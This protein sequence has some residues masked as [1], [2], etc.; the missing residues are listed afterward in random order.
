MKKLIASLAILHFA[1]LVFAQPTNDD[2]SGV[3]HLGTAPICPFPDTFSNLD[4]TQSVVFSS[5]TANVPSCF[6][7]GAVNRDVWFSFTVPAVGGQVDF[8]V[9]LTGVNG[10]NG[11]IVQP[12]IAAY[13]GDCELDGLS[14]LNCATSI[15]GQTNVSLDLIALDPGQLVYL[16][17]SDWSSSATPN[18]GDFELC[19]KA[20][21]PVYNMGE[22]GFTA[23]CAGTLYD[24]GGPTDDYSNNELQTFTICPQEFTQ[25]ISL[26]IVSIS[27][28]D[29]YDFLKIYAGE[30]T[31]SPLFASFSGFGTNLQLQVMGQCATFLFDSDNSANDEGFEI[32][33]EC[34]PTTCLISPPST[35]AAPTAIPALPY[36][37]TNLTT[38][39]SQNDLDTSPCNDDD[40]MQGE[41]VIFTYN[42]PGDEC[43]SV[44]ITGS[45]G[46][47]AIGI[48]DNCPEGAGPV[49]CLAQ[50]GGDSELSNPSING[51]F[52]ALP[53]TYYI[54][55]DN[56]NF[57]TP[58][59]IEVEEV[60]CP[61]I[62]PSAAFCENAQSIN[63][64][65]SL[66]SIVYIA[67][68]DGDPDFLNN[69]VNL[70]CWNGNV[71]QNY[72]F[73]YFEA[74]T[75]GDFAFVVQAANPDESSDID[76][77]V[78]GPIA[79]VDSIC[80]FAAT[81][82]PT[83]SSYGPY[84]VPTGLAY[85]NPNNNAVVTDTCEEAGVQPNVGDSFVL[86]IQVKAGEHYLVLIND[87][88]DVIESG[89]I[90]I[91]FS[92]TTEGVLASADGDFMTS[93]TD[94][95]IC[96]GDSVQLM[97]SGG[98]IF[99]WYP[100]TDLSCQYCP[101]PVSS[102]SENT[103]YHVA[104]HSLCE[105]DTI[106]VSVEILAVSAGPDLTICTGED[107]QIDAG[108]N[109]DDVQYQW[110][111]PAGFLSCND[112]PNPMVTGIQAGTFTISVSA[113]A[114]SCNLM[115]EMQL[116]VL[117]S[118]APVY[119]I[120]PDQNLCI[121]A[122]V[123]LGGA[124]IPGLIYNWT[125]N[126]PGFSS[127]LAN[128]ST[129]VAVNTIYYLEVSNGLCPVPTL[130]SVVVT[131]SA[132]P[133]ITVANDTSICA[134]EAVLLGNTQPEPNVTYSW[135]PENDLVS[136]NVANPIANP[137]QST[138]YTLI[139]DNNG[140][141]IQDSVLVEVPLNDSTVAI[142]QNPSTICLG[143][144]AELIA[145]APNGSQFSWE[146]SNSLSCLDCPAPVVNPT[147]TTEYSL[148]FSLNGCVIQQSVTVEVVA[149]PTFEPG[150]GTI[151]LSDSIALN[152]GPI[153]SGWAY[154]WSSSTYP[155]FSSDLPNPQ[156]SPTEQSTYSVEID[157]GICP[158][159]TFTV[160]VDL[161]PVP[162]LVI[163]QDTLVCDVVSILVTALT[164]EVGGSFTWS[165]GDTTSTTIYDLEDGENTLTVVYTSTCGDTL[166][167]DI[168][169]LKA[170]AP[171]VSIISEQD[172]VYQGSEII[173]SSEVN[174]PM[175][176]YSWSNGST[177]DTALVVPINL[178]GETYLV[179]VQDS[180]G[181]TATDSISL[182]VLEPRFEIPNAFSP[183]GDDINSVFRVVIKG[184]NIVVESME[185][186]NRWGQLVFEGKN[187]DGW[188]GKQEKKEAPSDVYIHRTL[189]RMPDGS[190]TIEKG[191][192]LLL[193]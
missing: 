171:T 14:E 148:N 45:N 169:V 17:I 70:G 115:D 146:F 143:Q 90:S 161:V 117:P 37:S 92:G 26:N 110:T 142:T 175:D 52:L 73:F 184:E 80:N 61:V 154:N 21:E 5:P 3:F 22:T 164:N 141:K 6:T 168:T 81:T 32:T 109:N 97:A 119:A 1:A 107:F 145:T 187:N 31:L 98:D 10:T 159:Q 100:P 49:N 54:V 23:A 24:S 138:I 63:G 174:H 89:A 82:E 4:A 7:G 77:Q 20:L 57:C 122:A 137:T 183:N 157:N 182:V 18:W 95:I 34:S 68:G 42:S 121:G 40:W 74:Q 78:W 29:N 152:N 140:C 35:C 116:T 189:V 83:R 25:C 9:E 149:P 33:W 176:S 120:S 91:D 13:R 43:I 108:P 46:A 147:E 132:P 104:I 75:D 88:G 188:D 191:E 56:P 47:T 112:C 173:L 19:V 144:F 172:T 30:S 94:T 181:C 153:E 71:T 53:D 93:T 186:W 133:Q 55:V 185:I 28:E 96:L 177:V 165:N 128:P 167:E 163:A 105:S 118:V 180:V 86:P 39:N 124:A 62:L 85:I 59:N 11:S 156:V 192:L 51:V 16:R 65:G 123:N 69:N 151:C 12:Q 79:S 67:P 190:L 158:P 87:Y 2:C 150:G 99:Q 129:N 114:P 127:N 111:A 179:T 125:S 72:T 136:P 64:C 131:V 36:A 139:A 76:F 84:D 130:D 135:A 38:C 60:T 41:D 126:P 178:E 66:P 15:Q 27:T 102:P 8:T 58:F 170:E 193:R 48:F 166:A 44:N 155:I 106:Q 101:S 160:E 50:E 162:S 134:G 103:T 113:L